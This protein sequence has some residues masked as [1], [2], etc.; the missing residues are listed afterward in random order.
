MNEKLN[1]SQM[2]RVLAGERLLHSLGDGKMAL[3]ERV[4]DSINLTV[5]PEGTTLPIQVK[6]ENGAGPSSSP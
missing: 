3:V 5:V 4:R 1:I 2:D 6:P